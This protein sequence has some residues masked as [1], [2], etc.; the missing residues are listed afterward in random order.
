[1]NESSVTST[2]TAICDTSPTHPLHLM[3]KSLLNEE[4]R[5]WLHDMLSTWLLDRSKL[6]Q[7]CRPC[8]IQ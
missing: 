8:V 7:G 5:Y 2:R 6:F 4:A 3:K 1:M